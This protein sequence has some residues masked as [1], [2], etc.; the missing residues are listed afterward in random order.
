MSHTVESFARLLNRTPSPE[1]LIK[2]SWTMYQCGKTF[3]SQDFLVALDGFNHVRRQVGEF[4]AR[5]DILLTP[6]SAILA[7]PHAVLDQDRDF[8]AAGAGLAPA[9]ALACR[10]REQGLRQRSTPVKAWHA[11]HFDP[12]SAINQA[13]NLSPT[14]LTPAR[15]GD[16]RK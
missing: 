12:S 10:T 5:Y 15:C 3:S 1:N 4:F 7:L 13:R 8:G 2:T 11:A 16:T 9:L 14:S 6:T